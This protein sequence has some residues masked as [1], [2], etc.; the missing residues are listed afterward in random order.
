MRYLPPAPR[1][2]VGR[3]AELVACAEAS[4]A[5][6]LEFHGPAGIGKTT[7]LAR[8]AHTAAALP[9]GVVFVIAA[10]KRPPEDLRRSLAGKRALVVLDDLGLEP[11]EVD[12]LL[13]AA[14]LSTFLIGSRKPVL[15]GRGRSLRLDGLA[16]DAG[17]VLLA[18]ELDRP[19]EADEVDAAR[20]LVGA[21]G[22]HPGRLV[23]VAAAVRT[24]RATLGE[25]AAT[26]PAPLSRRPR[27]AL[28]SLRTAV[29]AAA[30]VAL[31]AVALAL[32]AG[33]GDETARNPSPAP[34]ASL[35]TPAPAATQPSIA[36]VVP[37]DGVVY[38]DTGEVVP[39]ASYSCREAR[40]CAGPVAS[41]APLDT[42]TGTHEFTVTAVAEDGR[43]TR[44]VARYTVDPDPPSIRVESPPFQPGG[45]TAARFS[46][47]DALSGID[48]CVATDAGGNPIRDGDELP[49]TGSLTVT[50]T[51]RAGN[52]TAR[53]V[54]YRPPPAPGDPVT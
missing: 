6:P 3:D 12:A 15:R 30:A 43:T 23:A 13:D 10:G 48:S 14:P 28:P 39:R 17:V 44:A 35:A 5:S 25:L 54:D 36:I 32:S 8:V 49:L 21:L 42:R 1:M 26:A 51:D 34:Q 50:A 9:D 11:A 31:V 4:S 47:S 41:G 7:L 45:P 19:L 37:R 18:R 46:C 2:L 27:L 40:S 38:G 33:P 20:A 29:V 22:G 16:P 24:G 53:T 52:T